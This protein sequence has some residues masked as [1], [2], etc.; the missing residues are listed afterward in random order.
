MAFLMT[1]E[2]VRCGRIA[3]ENRTSCPLK[4]IR[5]KAEL[6]CHGWRL[7]LHLIPGSPGHGPRLAPLPFET[8]SL[9]QASETNK[10]DAVAAGS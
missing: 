8:H 7:L 5:L 2:E 3:R 6:W 10:E 1:A 4:L 9:V